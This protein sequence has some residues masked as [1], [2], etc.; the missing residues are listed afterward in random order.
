AMSFW[1]GLL[2]GGF[3]W[4]LLGACTTRQISNAPNA[5]TKYFMS[6]LPRPAMAE[7]FAT[8]P[9]RRARGFPMERSGRTT[10]DE[11]LVPPRHTAQITN[12]AQPGAWSFFLPDP[13][14][15]RILSQR[16]FFFG[17]AGCW[18][19]EVWPGGVLR[20]ALDAAF[21]CCEGPDAG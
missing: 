21:S 14:I 7:G 1:I 15:P 16:L 9:R 4:A 5:R 20:L 12:L 6:P 10:A 13:K 11:R 3:S 18:S 2:D 17:G 19:L 8:E